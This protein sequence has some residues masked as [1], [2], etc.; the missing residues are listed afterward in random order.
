MRTFKLY[1]RVFE[2]IGEKKTFAC[3]KNIRTHF[4]ANRS[5]QLRNETRVGD[6]SPRSATLTTN[7]QQELQ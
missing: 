5:I 6:L 2:A 7:R 4:Y 3:C 1:V